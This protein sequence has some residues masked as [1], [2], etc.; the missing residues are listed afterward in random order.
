MEAVPFDVLLHPRVRD[1]S[2]SL[3]SAGHCG[4]AALEA[5]IQVERAIREKLGVN[6]VSVGLMSHAFGE[7]GSIKLRVPFG[8]KLQPNARR[9]LREA[10]GYYRNYAAHDG[11]RFDSA[12]ALRAMVVASDLLELVGATDESFEDVSVGGLVKEGLFHNLFNVQDFLRLLDGRR[13]VDDVWD[14][15]WELLAAQ[16]YGERQLQEVVQTGLVECLAVP[17]P[18]PASGLDPDEQPESMD[19]WTPT[20]GGRSLL[21]K[22][23]PEVYQAHPADVTGGWS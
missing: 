9:F 20:P 21:K 2:A 11:A 5:F 17:V 12:L 22:R 4:H 15:Y 3:F 19:K 1:H 18:N 8:D 16:G 7:G 23:K 14:S 10:F 6:A 13:I